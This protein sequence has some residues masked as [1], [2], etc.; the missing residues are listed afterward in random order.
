MNKKLMNETSWRTM[1]LEC[2]Y[3]VFFSFFFKSPM[4]GSGKILS[5]HVSPRIH[6]RFRTPTFDNNN[7]TSDTHQSYEIVR[8]VLETV[9]IIVVFSELEAAYLNRVRVPVVVSIIRHTQ[10]NTLRRRGRSLRTI[11]PTI[12]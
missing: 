10:P 7:Y 12:T 4:R 9:R 5:W 1:A 3:H 2:K 8:F 6:K 11:M